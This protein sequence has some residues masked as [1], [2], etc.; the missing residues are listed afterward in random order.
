MP[1]WVVVGANG[2]LGQ[3]FTELLKTEDSISLS[4]ST[5]DVTDLENVSD[6]ITEA[7]YVINCAAYTSVDEAETHEDEAYAINGLGAANLAKVCNAI[8][9][10]LFHVS[11]DYV[12]PGDASIPYSENAETG[13]KS[14]YGR[15]KLAGEVEVK[16][17]LPDAHYIVRTAWLYGQHGPNFVKTMINLESQRD[18]ISVVN[19][20]IGQPTWTYDLANKI[21]ELARSDANPGIFHGTSSGQTSW[22]GFTR[23][24]FEL[25]GADPDRVLPATSSEFVRPA[26][27]PAFS[28]LGHHSWSQAKIEPIR[29][30]E[31][32]LA[33]A[34]ESGVFA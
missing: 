3:E 7:S 27:R 18:V 4:R 26:P 1:K 34:F 19:D 8:G 15:T 14:A 11:T 16:K 28:A 21:I 25:L 10:K 6:A 12:F 17:Y 32:G 2:M 22:F 33:T 20:Q 29:N 24:I 5:C 30:W 23:K 13:P 9:A 31:F